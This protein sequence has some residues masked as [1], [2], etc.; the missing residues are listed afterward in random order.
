[1]NSFF[2]GFPKQISQ[3]SPIFVA[4][5]FTLT[6][7]CI[8]N[9]CFIWHGSLKKYTIIFVTINFMFPPCYDKI[10]HHHGSFFFVIYFDHL[11]LNNNWPLWPS[12]KETESRGCKTNFYI[13][14]I[15]IHTYVHILAMVAEKCEL[16]Y[17]WLI[18][19]S[20]PK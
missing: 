3:K 14:I 6:I 9:H 1:M 17:N 13:I 8:K 11:K 7:N 16:N 19:Y 15:C 18:Q 2:C 20:F 10:K 4:S 5:Y 12:S